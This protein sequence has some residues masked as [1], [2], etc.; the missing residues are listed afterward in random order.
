MTTTLINEWEVTHPAY[1]TERDVLDTIDD[2]GE[3]IP[4]LVENPVY[5]FRVGTFRVHFTAECSVTL[6][7]EK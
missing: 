6:T 2:L 3:A 1:F 7:E 5:N 4:A